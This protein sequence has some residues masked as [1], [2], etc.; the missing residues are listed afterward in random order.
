[1]A[2]LV[3]Y[4]F[5][6]RNPELTALLQE[7]SFQG[8][9]EELFAAPEI[10]APSDPPPV[11]G[12]AVRL[13]LLAPGGR[14][15]R[16]GRRLVMIPAAAEQGAAGLLRDLSS[17]VEI[18]AE[19]G[20]ELR[21][22]YA[23]TSVAELFSWPQ[24]T[25]TVIAGLFLDLAMGAEVVRS[26]RISREP[27][28]DSVVWA[29]Q[30]ISAENAYG[31]GSVPA[32]PPR[33]AFFAELWHRKS[34][35]GSSRLSPAFIETLVRIGQGEQAGDPKELL[36][37]KHLK[38]VRS[39]GGALRLQIPAFGT[40]DA[41]RLLGPLTEGA[42][43]LVGDAIVPAL[44]RL[45]DHPWW[46]ERIGQEAYRHAAVRLILEHGIDH[47][48]AAGACDPFPEPES[49]PVE[50]GRCLWEEPEGPWT[51]MPHLV[52]GNSGTPR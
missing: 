32:A 30:G 40:A 11:W 41:Q 3:M 15:Y 7:Q 16:A 48:I 12:E 36:Y 25:H 10:A 38:L 35:R 33:R 52:S 6:D 43:R 24:A 14:G 28:G 9:V 8:L 39:V 20:A 27:T 19:V 51:V 13:E 34:R 29:F 46:R 21:S 44:E 22:V 4:V 1:V 23:Q 18:A 47:V 50:W 26:G 31:V 17:Y 49:T 37:L 2:Q 45:E 5:G 42:R